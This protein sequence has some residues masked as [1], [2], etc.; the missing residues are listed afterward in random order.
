MRYL[1]FILSVTILSLS[2]VRSQPPQ[3]GNTE[4]IILG[5]INLAIQPDPV[6]AEIKA[7]YYEP[8]SGEQKVLSTFPDEDGFFSLRLPVSF[9]RTIRM[10]TGH[11]SHTVSIG[12]TDTIRITQDEQGDLQFGGDYVDLNERLYEYDRSLAHLSAIDTFYARSK[13]LQRKKIDQ[14]NLVGSLLTNLQ[15]LA[16]ARHSHF[17]QFMRS[18]KDHPE[19]LADLLQQRIRYRLAK[20]WL[21]FYGLYKLRQK[22]D[23]A[24]KKAFTDWL[25]P[26]LFKTPDRWKTNEYL[27]FTNQY[28][29]L[30]PGHQAPDSLSTLDRLE[31]E[32]TYFYAL[33]SGFTGQMMMTNKLYWMLAHQEWLSMVPELLP[34][35]DE[36]VNYPALRQGFFAAYSA[37]TDPQ[38]APELAVDLIQI[39]ALPDS[40]KE[41]LPALLERHQGKVIVLDFWATWCAPCVGEFPAY[42]EVQSQFP[43]EAVVFIFITNTSSPENRWKATIAEYNLQGEHLRLESAQYVVLRK[44]FHFTGI[45]HHVL[46]DQRGR[47]VH[48]PARGPMSGMAKQISALIAN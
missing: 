48:N 3:S 25:A 12:P 14:N 15:F 27:L 34:L 30:N 17:N 42:P 43:E 19:G 11:I 38:K 26:S 37:V 20:E 5:K 33:D 28:Q 7:F 47:V 35:F 4:A 24:T 18:M 45:P 13:R 22:I 29:V 41:V 21:D 36:H 6:F 9:L 2:V 39:I 44:A 32:L 46:I 31:Q 23:L 40:I 10:G 8:I 1:L 16:K